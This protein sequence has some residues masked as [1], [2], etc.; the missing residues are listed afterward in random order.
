MGLIPRQPRT[1][2]HRYIR[3]YAA[4]PGT[5]WQLWEFDA[6]YP[7]RGRYR[8]VGTA[9]NVNEVTRFLWHEDIAQ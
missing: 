9:L 2:G 3:A 5:M 4:F 8:R 1:H 6:D 7:P